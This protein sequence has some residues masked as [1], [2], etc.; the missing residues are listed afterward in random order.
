MVLSAL[1]SLG[2]KLGST[3]TVIS[4]NKE[5]EVAHVRLDTNTLLA[6]TAVVGDRQCY[7]RVGTGYM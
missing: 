1:I 2:T 5:F 6:L 4:V 3:E 7:M